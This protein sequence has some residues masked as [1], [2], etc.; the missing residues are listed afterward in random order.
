MKRDDLDFLE[1]EQVE[2]VMS[3]YGKAI[4]KKDKEIE[5][6]TNSK[7]ELEDKVTT[8]ETKINEFNE[9]AKDNADWKSKY[10]E[11]QTSIKEQEAKKKAE[12]EDKILTDN[13]NA[14]FEG[15]KFT[16]DYARNGLMNDIKNGLNNPENKGKGIQDLF[17][18]LTKDK[19]DIF[20]NPNQQKDMEGMGDSEQDNNTKEM[21]IIW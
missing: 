12:E 17:N 4:A 6:L 14:L 3:L 19:T 13:I 21:P 18:E 10:E 15:K 1:S 5:T 20:A 8:Y 7:K 9:S 11:L 16:S 2:K